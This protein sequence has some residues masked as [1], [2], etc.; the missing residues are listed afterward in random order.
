MSV[1]FMVFLL[2]FL[3]LTAFVASEVE[4]ILGSVIALS[5]FGVLMAIA[6]S[7]LQ[8]PDVALTQAVINSGLVTSLFLVAYSQTS[9]EPPAS[10]GNVAL[11][12]GLRLAWIQ[13]VALL[14]CLALGWMLWRGVAS[15]GL[16]LPL[17]GPAAHFLEASARETGAANVVAAILFDYRGFD[18]LGEATVIFA[19]VCG[20]ALLFSKSKARRSARGLSFIARRGMALI[21]PFILLY[22]SSIVA[23]GHL[24]PGGGFQGGAVF[25]TAT[26]L[27]CIVYGSNF[28]AARVSPR[29]KEF[30]ESAGGLLFVLLGLVGLLAGAGFLANK[31]AGFPLG[32]AGRFLSGGTIPLLNVAVALKVGAGLST[33]FYSMIKILETE[34]PRRRKEGN[35]P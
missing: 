17:S 23:F 2:A 13:P 15:L 31:A 19:T 16:P 29:V 10:K 14:L 1:S 12:E 25:A 30:M 21:V 7:I 35:L 6:F 18:T 27:F 26:I 28:E 9:K 5:V 3:V 34:E 11:K 8:A 22:G 20:I 4:D 32:S 33:I 24:S